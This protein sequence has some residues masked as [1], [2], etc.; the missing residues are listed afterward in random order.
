MWVGERPS[1]PKRCLEGRIGVV[2]VD[3]I[4]AG[5]I[6]CGAKGGKRSEPPGH[7]LYGDDLSWVMRVPLLMQP[8]SLIP[9]ALVLGG[10][11]HSSNW[12]VMRVFMELVLLCQ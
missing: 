10:R 4:K 7:H 5:L 1:I 3:V 6:E 9:A 12:P 8:K 2:S 11:V